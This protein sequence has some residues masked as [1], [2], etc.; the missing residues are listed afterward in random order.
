MDDE[1]ARSLVR[2]AFR[3]TRDLQDVL[4]M[5]KSRLPEDAYK[6]YALAIA[7]AIHAVNEALIDK[8]LQERPHLKAEIE[9][10]IEASG[11]Y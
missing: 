1:L 4:A 10:S 2:S 8:P 7:A 5:L 9:A 6:G 3:T 11:R